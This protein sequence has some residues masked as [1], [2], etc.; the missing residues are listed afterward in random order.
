MTSAVPL[1]LNRSSGPIPA[2]RAATGWSWPAT[3][4]TAPA[5]HAGDLLVPQESGR[6]ARVQ[7]VRQ[8]RSPAARRAP[9]RRPTAVRCPGRSGR[10][11]RPATAR[12]T[13]SPPRPCTIH[14]GTLSHLLPGAM[15]PFGRAA[16]AAWRWSPGSPGQAGDAGEPAGEGGVRR[17]R[18][19]PRSRRD[20]RT[21]RS[22]APCGRPAGSSRMPLSPI[23]PTE[24]ARI[25]TGPR[26]LRGLRGRR[27]SDRRPRSR[28][29]D[30]VQLGTP[31]ELGAPGSGPLHDE[32]G[33]VRRAG[34]SA[35]WRWW[36][37][38]RGR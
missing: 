4:S 25:A 20:G 33:R 35:P 28:T 30:A 3:L 36:C 27:R 37:R 16:T 11:G 19:P 17:P 18:G 12:G 1:E 29:P 21:R 8:Q 10:S 9:A 14:S 7:L 34:G 2:P 23:P 5:A 6:P 38:C 22:P 32:R 24:T 15:R 31:A 13:R 26:R